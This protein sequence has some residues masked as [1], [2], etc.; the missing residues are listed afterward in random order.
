[1]AN[2][3]RGLAIVGII[4]AMATPQ[5]AA[6]DG[7]WR[8]IFDG[9]SL[10]GWTPKIVGQAAGADPDATFIVQDGAIRVSYANYPAF[11]GRFGHLF[12]QTPRKAYRLRLSYRILDPGL[13]DAPSWARANSGVM[14]HAQSPDSMGLNQPFPA[15]LEFQILGRDGAG[16]RPTGSICTPG[17]NITITGAAVKAH[18]TLSTGP[19]IP[20]GEWVK[21]ELAVSPKG[22]VTHRINGAVVHRYAGLELDPADSTARPLITG[23]GGALSL[24]EGFIALQSEGHPIEF[25][26]IQIQTL[27]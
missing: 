10:A 19:T 13:A 14:F 1:M 15:S 25:R 5:G 7:R 11:R 17:T 26:D 21:L 27:K 23:R 4:L 3:S 20:N 18:C 24:T 8:P 2:V 9:K 6:A 22:E 12:H 16:P